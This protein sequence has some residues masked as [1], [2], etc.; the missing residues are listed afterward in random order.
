MRR[1]ASTVVAIL[2][3]AGASSAARADD[4]EE[5]PLA[6]IK[7]HEQELEKKIQVERDRPDKKA[8][9]KKVVEHAEDNIRGLGKQLQGAG[10][11]VHAAAKRDGQTTS[12]GDRKAPSPPPQASPPRS[13][14]GEGGPRKGA[15]PQ[16]T[17]KKTETPTP[18]KIPDRSGAAAETAHP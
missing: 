9:A 10:H 2:L 4:S 17:E 15:A 11:E 1:L 5:H 7:K 12:G 3:V 14:R 6:R 8:H 16:A 18:G 13:K